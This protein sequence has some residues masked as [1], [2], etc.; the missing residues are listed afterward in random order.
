MRVANLSRKSG[1]GQ[2]VK[3]YVYPTVAVWTHN[4]QPGQ[5][6]TAHSINTISLWSVCPRQPSGQ[7]DL[8]HIDQERRS[9]RYKTFY[10]SLWSVSDQSGNIYLFYYTAGRRQVPIKKSKILEMQNKASQKKRRHARTSRRSV[11]GGYEWPVARI[12]LWRALECKWSRLQPP[13]QS[14][15][16]AVWEHQQRCPVSQRQVHRCAAG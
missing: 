7:T 16:P 8:R 2:A 5:H 13:P 1:T 14:P 4:T 3:N 12:S 6:F 15:E 11:L 9:R 10:L